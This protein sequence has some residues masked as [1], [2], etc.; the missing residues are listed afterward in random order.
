MNIT[1]P[2]LNRFQPKVGRLYPFPV[3][4]YL[5]GVWRAD[6]GKVALLISGLT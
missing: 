3:I 1:Q 4:L 6:L 2:Q 5:P